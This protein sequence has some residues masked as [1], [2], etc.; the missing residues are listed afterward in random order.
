MSGWFSDSMGFWV[1]GPAASGKSELVRIWMTAIREMGYEVPLRLSIF[2]TLVWAH[3]DTESVREWLRSMCVQTDTLLVL[4]ELDTLN[5][6]EQAYV[7]ELAVR[8]R[9]RVIV[10]AR[11]EPP[12]SLA[13]EF[14]LHTLEPTNEE[15]V[16]MIL[17]RETGDADVSREAAKLLRGSPVSVAQAIAALREG[18]LGLDEI[19]GVL[20][21]H[22]GIG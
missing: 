11:N 2:Y 13:D 12:V 7:L 19:L 15:A 4:D 16:A 6:H 1:Q 9:H 17:Q 5:I 8:M 3:R 10:I 18:R 20:R 21:R 22:E 14:N